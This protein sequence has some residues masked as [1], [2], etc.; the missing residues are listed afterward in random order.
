MRRY[1]VVL[2]A[3]AMLPVTVQGQSKQ[4][5]CKKWGKRKFFEVASPARVAE[6]LAQGARA[7]AYRGWETPLHTSIGRTPHRSVIALL[8]RAGADHSAPFR[9]TAFKSDTAALCGSSGRWPPRKDVGGSD[10]LGS[11]CGRE[12]P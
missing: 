12:R 8:I 6:C 1:F 7:T 9:K 2:L 5:D 3:L 10:A 11:G 4:A